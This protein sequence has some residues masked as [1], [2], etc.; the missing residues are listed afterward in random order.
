MAESAE[1]EGQ[2]LF[3]LVNFNREFSQLEFT[4]RTCIS[5]AFG[6]LSGDVYILLADIETLKLVEALRRLAVSRGLGAKALEEL[7]EACNA[8]RDL[9][10]DR[11]DV[12]Q[13][14]YIARAMDAGALPR[15]DAALERGRRLASPER[16]RLL[17]DRFK[18][19][20]QRFSNLVLPPRRDAP[21]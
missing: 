20:S 5:D 7:D 9:I 3:A 10:I 18:T 1:Q 16:L 21:V 11:V 14:S 13:V 6:D 19:V 12:M 4:I 8:F 2:R 15:V 17:S